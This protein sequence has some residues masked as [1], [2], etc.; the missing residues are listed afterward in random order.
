[1][2][3]LKILWWKINLKDV[4]QRDRSPCLSTVVAK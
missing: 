2:V 3:S 1:M 4:E